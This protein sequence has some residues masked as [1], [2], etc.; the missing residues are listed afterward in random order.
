VT[1]VDQL[2]EEEIHEWIVIKEKKA[3]KKKLEEEALAKAK[4]MEMLSRFKAFEDMM[5]DAEDDNDEDP[6]AVDPDDLEE[7]EEEIPISDATAEASKGLNN[8][9]IRVN[10]KGQK[11]MVV[12]KFVKKTRK[13]NGKKKKK[14]TSAED[15]QKQAAQQRLQGFGFTFAE[16]RQHFQKKLLSYDKKADKLQQERM[17]I[18]K[19]RI[20]NTSLMRRKEKQVFAYQLEKERLKNYHGKTIT[21]SVLTGADMQ[22]RTLDYIGKLNTAYE[23]IIHEIANLKYS[24]IENEN[25]RQQINAELILNEEQKKE[26]LAKYHEFESYYTKTMRIMHRL[27]LHNQQQSSNMSVNSQDSLVKVE[28]ERILKLYF[29]KILDNRLEMKNLKKRI[30]LM[31]N[32]WLMRY[33]KNAFNKLKYSSNLE[34]YKEQEAEDLKEHLSSMGSVLLEEAYDKRVELQDELRSILS[35][36]STIKQNLTLQQISNR[37]IK[38]L[39]TQIT[40]Q[41]MEEGMNHYNLFHYQNV[42]ILYEANLYSQENKFELAA[43]LYD[44]QILSIRSKAQMAYDSIPRQLKSKMF[45]NNVLSI[46]DIKVLAICHGKLGEMFVKM[47]KISRAIVE[48]D[49]QLSLGKEISDKA[50]ESNAYYG[51]G[52]GYFLNFDY[53]NAL[54]Y[55]VIAQGLFLAA[56]R[57]QKY[58]LCLQCIREC[59]VKI[60]RADK[61]ALYDE[62]LLN[63]EQTIHKKCK[64]IMEILKDMEMRLAH[65]SAEIEYVIK[66]ERTTYQ[67]MECKKFIVEREEDLNIAQIELAKQQEVVH[68]IENVLDAL[69]KEMLA[70]IDTDELEMWSELVHETP[71]VVEIEELKKR[72]KNR[73]KIEMEELQTQKSQEN[74]ILTKIRNIENE[75]EE[76]HQLLSLEEGNLMK[77]ARFDKPFRVIGLCMSNALGNEVTGTATGGYEEFAAAE[78]NNIHIIDYHTGELRHIMKGT[79]QS[80]LEMQQF[81]GQEDNLGHTGV[82]TCLLHD[83]ALIFSGSTDERIICWQTMTRRKIRT[84]T[85]HEGSIVALA[86]ETK[87]LISSSADVTMRLWLKAT[88]QQMRVVFGHSK[89]VLTMEIGLK[90]LVTGSA[91]TEVRLWKLEEVSSSKTEVETVTKLQGHNCAV[92]C[93]KYGSIEIL[94]GD[95]LG[96]VFIWWLKTGTVLRKCEIH[97]GPI[98]CLQFDSVHI[99]TGSTDNCV[100]VTDIAS[101]EVL[102]SLRGHEKSVL[103]LAFDSERILSV[104]G[105]NTVRYWAWGKKSGP[106]DKFH[107]L[108][109]NETIAMVSK[110]YNVPIDT[111]MKWNGIRNNR[112]VYTG[113]KLIVKKGDP[114]KLTDAER[115]NEEREMRQTRGLALT[116]KKMAKTETSISSLDPEEDNL[117]KKFSNKSLIS[118]EKYARIHSL[119]MNMD[120]FSLG[121]RL[122]GNEK[123]KLDLFPDETN[124]D[125]DNYSLATRIKLGMEEKADESIVGGEQHFLADKAGAQNVSSPSKVSKRDKDF[126]KH[127]K[128]TSYYISAENEDEWGHVSDAIGET[129]ID[130]M[131]ELMSYDVVLDQKR[132][133]RDKQSVIGRIYQYQ[134]LKK[135]STDEKKKKAGP[136]GKVNL[137]GRKKKRKKIIQANGT[138]I[139]VDG[140]SVDGS[141]VVSDNEDYQSATSDSEG[142]KGGG[143]GNSDSDQEGNSPHHHGKRPNS[144][145][146]T[147]GTTILHSR[148]EMVPIPEEEEEEEEGEDEKDDKNNDP[149][150]RTKSKKHK[151][152][153]AF[154]QQEQAINQ[155]FDDMLKENIHGSASDE[156]SNPTDANDSEQNPNS[157][158]LPQI[159]SRAEKAVKEEPIEEKEPVYL[160]PIPN[161][162][163]P[164]LPK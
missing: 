94:S 3:M 125:S 7:V 147:T 40:F 36:M 97:Q 33:K 61:V 42:Q 133:N 51:L 114:N 54:R 57:I 84:L 118:D 139:S 161:T 163:L 64:N 16:R 107:I 25:R 62:K 8:D 31:F 66:I 13:G 164:P 120:Y 17:I 89:S 22:Y 72:L 154:L 136:S 69:Q 129:M 131:I 15:S 144:R 124:K 162:T 60:H 132:S 45:K 122:F 49:R 112:N 157:G 63:T 67:A 83:G 19:T 150:K 46:Q 10:S 135:K 137:T 104:G 1:A 102:Q 82:V 43:R 158:F 76:K 12:K 126:R 39:K 32:N 93:V 119:A 110:Q 134:N 58:Y 88:G 79:V 23:N 81:T 37:N 44:A 103:A 5:D 34:K 48:F 87:Y 77:H 70:A 56:N 101:G 41:N 47:N 90:W 29:K 106:Q 65:T 30:V 35:D 121:N 160:P 123:R 4:E 159:S 21:S 155:Y 130:M 108:E 100:C 142:E 91:D 71:Q 68:K 156:K 149:E 24:I 96:R 143:G 78:G 6:N 95:A 115:I 74:K 141:T 20:E 53:E 2:E 146:S 117:K 18:D 27:N 50:E 14:T 38:K 52:Q 140:S 98:K 86:A 80:K 9:N 75:I 113:M 148:E 111:L 11:V 28:N 109:P 85:G 73:S 127:L 151:K 116:Q 92:T 59:Y 145:P 152:A 26:R 105:D 99:V 55:L 138:E 128:K 153:K